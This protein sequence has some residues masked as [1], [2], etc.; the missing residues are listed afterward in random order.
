[1]CECERECECECGCECASSSEVVITDA[2][3]HEPKLERE[4][5]DRLR[6][7]DPAAFE[8]KMRAQPIV[9]NF[10]PKSRNRS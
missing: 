3:G 7:E 9:T 5:N 1:M 2:L 10:S 6:A 8:A 4:A